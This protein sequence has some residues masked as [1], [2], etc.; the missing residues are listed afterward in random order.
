MSKPSPPAK[1]TA[2]ATI[3]G[4]LAPEGLFKSFDFFN[5]ALDPFT[6]PYTPSGL[7]SPMSESIY[8][9]YDYESSSS[10]A[11]S[12]FADDFSMKYSFDYDALVSKLD[13]K[14]QD[15]SSRSKSSSSSS[16][17]GSLASG[18]SRSSSQ[19]SCDGEVPFAYPPSDPPQQSIY[20]SDDH[21]RG[22]SPFRVH[23]T[24]PTYMAEET[25]S[26]TDFLSHSPSLF[27]PACVCDSSPSK[28]CPV[29]PPSKVRAI[30][31]LFYCRQ[32]KY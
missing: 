3:H 29:H 14:M 11:S 1:Y 6:P 26:R 18:R 12:V 15:R 17:R 30:S 19:S 22:R 23:L 25:P 31:R 28:S 7:H 20:E 4:E 8:S 27:E 24:A 9:P 5:I 32:P 10:D 16:S 21:P 13:Q 2:G